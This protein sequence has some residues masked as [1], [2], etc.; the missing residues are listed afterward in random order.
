[1][2]KHIQAYFRT[3]NDA[4]D[5]RIRL[6]TYQ[7]EQ[8]EVGETEGLDRQTGIL[9]PFGYAGTSG[10]IAVPGTPVGTSSG[11]AGFAAVNN[12]EAEHD[13]D[14]I[15]RGQNDSLFGGD[16]DYENL[17]YVL[18]AKVPENDYQEIVE[19]IR[20]NNGYVEKMD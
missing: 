10:N 14:K 20:N 13:P 11:P 6:Q 1:M 18:S 2:S 4:E 3:E 19:L 16:D 7:A 17:R 8:I 15:V 5:V 12:G 9:A